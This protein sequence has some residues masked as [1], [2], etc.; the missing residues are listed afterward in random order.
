[1]AFSDYFEQYGLED[2]PAGVALAIAVSGY[3]LP[4]FTLS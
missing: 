4:R 1:M 2:I 3:M